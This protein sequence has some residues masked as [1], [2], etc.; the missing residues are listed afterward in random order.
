MTSQLLTTTQRSRHS[1]H[2]LPPSSPVPRGRESA[3]PTSML[4]TMEVVMPSLSWKMNWC[5]W[6]QSA[7]HQ[8]TILFI[9]F[10][11]TP[12]SCVHIFKSSRYVQLHIVNQFTIQMLWY[13]FLSMLFKILKFSN[14]F[15]LVSQI[16]LSCNDLLIKSFFFKR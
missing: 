7:C 2:P 1:S 14:K 15:Y 10:H 6:K 4:C 9:I 5:F 8:F 13:T 11:V 12:Y 16:F 3:E